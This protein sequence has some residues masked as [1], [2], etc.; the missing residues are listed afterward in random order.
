MHEESLKQSIV[1][2]IKENGSAAYS[3]IEEVMTEAGYDWRGNLCTCSN[4]NGN[5]VF[6]AGLSGAAGTMPN[7]LGKS[8]NR[9]MFATEIC[10]MSKALYRAF[11]RAVESLTF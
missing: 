11:L 9:L 4:M 2:Y 10:L 5:A 7:C 1:D 6:W 3:E 8:R